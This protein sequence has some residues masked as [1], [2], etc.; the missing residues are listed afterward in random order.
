M[1]FRT[2]LHTSSQSDVFLKLGD[3]ALIIGSC[4]SEHIGKKLQS[5]KFNVRLNP[6][7]I[8]YNPVSLGYQIDRIISKS[9]ISEKDLRFRDGLWHSYEHHGMFSD[10]E[11][12]KLLGRANKSLLNAAEHLKAAKFLFLTFGT[13][14]VFELKERKTVVSNCHKFPSSEFT[15]RLASI[16]E[17]YEGLH[18]ALSRVIEHNSEINIILSI[19]PVRYLKNGHFSNQLSKARLIELVYRLS[20]GFSR[21]QYFPAYEIFMDDLRDYR[22]YDDD[23]IHPGPQGLKYI[24]EKF[25]ASFI[26][27]QTSFDIR[28]IDKLI[29]AINHRPFNPQLSEH[30]DFIE[31][32][33]KNIDAIEN[34]LGI[35]FHDEKSELLNRLRSYTAE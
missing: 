2:E 18:Q 7:G 29:K 34:E 27:E 1:K 12:E 11:P 32:Q 31:T 26:D 15:H 3:P 20:M 14:W 13:S 22:Y 33:L 24:W 9:L 23:L 16:D 25:S 28:R 8:V 5:L 19:S 6:F 4:F 21:V 17:T 30:I 35:S 10:A